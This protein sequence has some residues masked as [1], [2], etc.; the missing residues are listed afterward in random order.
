MASRFRI[1]DLTLDTGRCLLLRD[2]KPIPLGRLTYR[3]L[4]TLAEAA[5]NV[6]THDELARAIW[7]GRSVSGSNCCETPWPTILPVRAMSKEFAA[8]VTGWCRESKSCRTNRQPLI[9]TSG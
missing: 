9:V 2:A 1:R 8:R 5:P 7:G 3:L 6:V 4:L